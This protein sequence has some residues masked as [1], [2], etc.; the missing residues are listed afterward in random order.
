[1]TGS[2]LLRLTTAW[3]VLAV[4]G[5]VQA[6]E[7]I[8]PGQTTTVT[9]K[10]SSDQAYACYLPGRYDPSR[11]WPILYCFSPYGNGTE[12]VNLFKDACEKL[13]WIVVGSNNVQNGP[14][15][16]IQTTV[17]A[18]WK[19]T[20][21][22]FNLSARRCYATGF[23][24]GSGVALSMALQHKED[25]SGIVTLALGS[26]WVPL[27]DIP[28]HIAVY[29][30]IGDQEEGGAQVVKQ[31]AETLG[32]K[33]QKAEAKTFPGEHQLPPADV[34]GGAV[35]WMVGATGRFERV[36]KE[37]KKDPKRAEKALASA[38]KALEKEKKDYAMIV[39]KL[40]EG[41]DYGAAGS[42]TVRNAEARLEEVLEEGRTLMAGAEG[43]KAKETLRKIAKDF[44][45]TDIEDEAK[46]KLGDKKPK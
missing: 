4:C 42:E 40:L 9:C 27:P 21:A 7:E 41:L 16:P 29:F 32:K 33:G 34:A 46:A 24:G 14:W 6:Q 13:G 30:I 38:V 18:M 2:A 25:F 17:D 8:A 23:S 5:I 22:R 10:D 44:E 3:A 35:A 26:G 15:E 20:H 28:A 19:D 37:V 36:R 43:E 39:K 45:G 1:M 12:L 31:Y 11:K